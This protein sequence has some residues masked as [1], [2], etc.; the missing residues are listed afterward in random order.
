MRRV[1]G[2]VLVGALAVAA[3]CAA[4]V[5]QEPPA[6]AADGECGVRQDGCPPAAPPAAPEEPVARRP[7]A[8][9]AA[10]GRPAPGAGGAPPQP[11]GTGAA[12]QQP[13][14]PQIAALLAA[15]AART[16]AQRKIGSDLL[17]QAASAA[18]GA[19]PG[20]RPPPP[21]A[22]PAPAGPAGAGGGGGRVLVDIRADVTPAVLARIRALGGTVVNSVP[23]YRAIRARLPLAGLEPLAERADV[24]WIRAAD[25]PRIRT[26]QPVAAARAADP[27]APAAS[28][29]VDTSEG[30]AAHRADAAR[31]AHGVDGTGIGVGVI[32]DGVE[33]L[34]AQ[35][36][37]GDVPA[38][39]TILPGQEGGAFDV[40]CGGRS[41]GSEGTA[42][43][44]IVHDLAPGAEL[45][46][47]DGGGGPAQMAQNIEDLCTAGADVIVDDIAYLLAPAL[48]DGV[49]AR[50]VSAVTARGCH[51]FSAAG[52]GGNLQHRTSAVWEGDFAAGASLDLDGVASG[53]TYHDFG[54]GA[55]G[56]GIVGSGMY[57]MSLQWSDPLGAS[58]ND[59]DLFLIGANDNVIASSTNT[60]DGTQDPFEYFP[61]ACAG[62]YAGA[63]LVIVRNAGA[64][65]RYLRL[66]AG[67]ALGIAT[68]GNTFGHAASRQAVGVGAVPV[69]AEGGAFDATATVEWFSSDGPRRIFFEADGTA[70]TPG[71]YSSAGGR[72]LHKPDVAAANAVSTS[73]PGFSP[74][75]GTSAAAP[76]AAAI[77]ALMVEAAGGPAHLA[78]AA[79]RAALTANALD[80]LAPGVDAASGAG[81]ALAPGA[82]DAVDVV[83]ADRNRAPT[84]TAPAGRPAARA[85]RRHGD[86]RPRR[87][88]RRS[89]RRCADLLAAPGRWRPGRAG[90]V[91]PDPGARRAGDLVHG[92]GERERPRRP[93][94]D[95]DLPG[96]DDHGRPVRVRGDA[97]APRRAVDGR[98]GAGGGDDRA[99]LRVDGGQRVGV[100]GGGERRDGHGAG[101]G[102]LHGGG[103]RGRPAAGRAGGG[104]PTGDGLPGVADGVHGPSHRAGRDAGQGDP[105]PGAAGARRRAAGGRG[106]AGVPVDGP[107]ADARGDADPQCARDGAAGGAG[108]GVRRRGASGAGLHRPADRG[109]RDR[110]QGGA[111]DGAAGGGGVARVESPTSIR[112]GCAPNPRRPLAGTPAPPR[113]SWPSPTDT[114]RRCCLRPG[115][116][117]PSSC[118]RPPSRCG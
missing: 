88:L 81:I 80:I 53:A 49:I 31:R 4:R 40:A 84:V 64:A 45:F 24:Q 79:L 107:G 99:G 95:A 110:H 10:R 63:R 28:R 14:A 44:E 106:P 91:R 37:T 46:F 71:D 50:A 85:G 57:Y 67:S 1:R 66:D 2:L 5:A 92:G 93:D 94:H 62:E 72:L 9:A 48:Q 74:F 43:M 82:V 47:A 25:Q 38:H 98:R 34:A 87:R 100:P 20:D 83:P 108:R 89:G 29:K 55:T 35:Q 117:A 32:S 104:G 11:A 15:K 70:I 18:A 112:R 54:R 6:P 22:A 52:N 17:T 101:R 90:R 27:A 103:E 56:N 68:G 86:G 26:Q 13:G 51:Y 19:P 39:V 41:N 102:A 111:P 76:H 36:A 113:R 23:R 105:L 97:A 59:Y 73:T 65:D 118:A 61:G 77:G 30:D 78:P 116:S 115:R 33:T 75:Y 7:V 60:Q 12:P 109:R 114:P 96:R 69:P 58:D 3:A 16:P 42:M 21:D 8:P